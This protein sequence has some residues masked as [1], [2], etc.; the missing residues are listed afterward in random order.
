MRRRSAYT[1]LELILALAIGLV[2]LGALYA[3]LSAHLS[4]VQSGREVVEDGTL[5]RSVLTR[6]IQDVR[7]NLGARDPRVLPDESDVPASDDSSADSSNSSSTDKSTTKSSTTTP[8]PAEDTAGAIFNLGVQGSASQLTLFV[9]RV[10]RELNL[11]GGLGNVPAGL[12]SDL[13]RITYWIT[14]EG[15]GG[16]ACEEVVLVTGQQMEN[17]AADNPRPRIIASEVKKVEFQYFDGSDWW[18]DWDGSIADPNLDLEGSVP[19][20]PPSA[21]AVTITIVR[22]GRTPD[23]LSSEHTYRQVI[24]IPAGNNYPQSGG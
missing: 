13:R 23:Q 12:A 10:P 11:T 1:L 15:G 18:N 9:S 14:D 2:I 7:S 8:K 4:G 21:I 19:R 16:L 20:G 17:F 22:P 24:A 6:F 5:A 3:T